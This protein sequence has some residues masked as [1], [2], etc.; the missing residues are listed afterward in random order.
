[1]QF[2]IKT[3]VQPENVNEY[4]C[5][6]L[7]ALLYFAQQA[8]TG[9]C[10]ELGLDWD[11]MAEKNLFWAVIRHRVIIDRLP[12]AGEN[13][14]LRTWPMPTTRTY[15]PRTVQGLDEQGEILFQVVSM[16]VLMDMQTRSMVLPGKSG[17]DVSGVL[18]GGE[19]DMPSSLHPD[20]R[21]NTHMWTVS[22]QDLDIN[23]HVNNAKYLKHAENLSGDYRKDHMPAE[24][25][26]CYNAEARLGQEIQ[27]NWSL[28]DGVLSVDGSRQNP[29]GKPDR[30][31]SVKITYAPI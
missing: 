12:R 6:E 4:G 11:T 2:E 20:L 29:D 30:I 19:P 14:T 3:T 8:A 5:L 26:V 9:H 31:F 23:G 25:V 28:T 17:I 27:L 15:Y 1:M 13:I 7:S 16:W 24:V 10:D 18:Q 21:D 22:R